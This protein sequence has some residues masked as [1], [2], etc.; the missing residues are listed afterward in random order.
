M[1][2]LLTVFVLSSWQETK[3]QD[4]LETVV[5]TASRSP[6]TTASTTQSVNTVT[7]EDIIENGFRTLP[8]ALAFTPGVSVQK[9]THG[10]GSPFIRGFTGRQNLYLVD[11][12]RFNNSTFRSGPIQYANTIDALGLDRFELVKSQ[13][14]VLYGSDALGGT[15][16]AITV[17]SGYQDQAPGFFQNGFVFYRYD[18]NSQSHVGRNQQT[19]GSGGK[20]GITLG[21]TLK[22]F[23]DIR[24]DY[25]GTMRGTGYPEQNYDFKLELALAENHQ[26][27]LAH[28]FLNQDDVSRWH[29]TLENPGGWEGL[30]PGKF[31][32]RFYDQERSLS[33][34]RLEGEP[35]SGPVERYRA[36]F[37]FQ[38]SQDSEFQDR[39]PASAQTR[40]ANIDTETYGITLEA[41]SNLSERTSLLYGADYYEDQIDSEGARNGVFE[42]RRRPL[43]D[44][45]TYR[46]LGLF[47][48]AKHEFNDCFEISAGLRYTYAEADLGKVWDGSEDIS[49]NESWDA[50]VGS[51]RGIYKLDEEWSLFGGISQ[52]F[53]APNV[54]DLSGN[55]TTRSG[56]QN[57]GNLDLDPER[58]ITFELGGRHRSDNFNFEV[59]GFY[60]LVDD[61]ITRVP[62]SDVDS[63]TVTVNGGEAWIAG[64]E[65]QGSWRFC[66]HWTLSGFLT[67]QYGDADRPAFFGG[68]E[69]T[70]PVSRIAP[71]RGSLALRYDHPSG[72]WWA[73]A[74]VIAAAEQDRLAAN[75]RGDTQR[76]PPGGTPSYFTGSIFAGYQ[77]TE[78]LQLNLAVQ[79]LTD[80]DFRVHG[81]GLN[82]PG[83]GAT[84]GLKY[85]W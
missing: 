2:A 6:E 64:L 37:S 56:V 49:A 24:S 35:T 63:S 26:L 74:R 19:F 13:G 31:T 82:E 72:K 69:V 70:E 29:S 73:E 16:N 62:R 3:A 52:G 75:D 12:I 11:G 78:N 77:A 67:Y 59:A 40:F 54:N 17:T 48:Q 55:V 32:S 36:T 41:Q 10:H 83:L 42:P 76:I 68:P 7:N 47:T 57:R 25:Y 65:A 22:D 71:L 8:E 44:D 1:A 84:L 15:L 85:S 81:S 46:S 14:S 39:N 79:N 30:A 28:Q 66:R 23:G 27:T 58:T 34:L 45:A 18:T 60:T 38:K 20:W 61:L 21:T 5:V 50:F 80:D 51:V 9:T 43:A 33:Y 53:R 4:F